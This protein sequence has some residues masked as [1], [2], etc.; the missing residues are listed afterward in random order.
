MIDEAGFAQWL[1]AYGR[2]W[3]QGDATGIRQLFAPGAAY[4]ETP[5]DPP[6]VGL[7]ALQA[8][9][10]AGAAD[11]QRDVAFH[12]DVLAVSGGRGIARWAATFVRVPSGMG[13]RLDG[14][15]TA[16]FD[17][18]GRCVEFRE[19]WHRQETPAAA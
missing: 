6:M 12:Y 1:D 4:Y 8:Y 10:Q 15:L 17:A 7:D 13:V 14:M 3:E 19:W 5:F 18:G 2:A 16:R 9:W 11:A